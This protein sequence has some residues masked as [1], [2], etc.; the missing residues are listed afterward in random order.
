MLGSC[1]RIAE[2]GCAEA[3]HRRRSRSLLTGKGGV[4]PKAFLPD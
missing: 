2:A 1:C 3:V 4:A